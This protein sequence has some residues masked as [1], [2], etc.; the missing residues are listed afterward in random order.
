MAVFDIQSKEEREKL[1]RM[2]YTFRQMDNE[3][4]KSMIK[5]TRKKSQELADFLEKL[6]KMDQRNKKI[7][8]LADDIIDQLG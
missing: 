5:S 4:Q 3:E 8:S 2:V 7:D 6:R 1:R